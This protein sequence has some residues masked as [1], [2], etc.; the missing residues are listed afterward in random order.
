MTYFL[1][2]GSKSG[3]SMLAQNIAKSLPDRECDK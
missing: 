2:G 1:S 3:K